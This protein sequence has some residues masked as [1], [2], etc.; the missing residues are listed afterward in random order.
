MEK[1]TKNASMYPPKHNENDTKDNKP[2]KTDGKKYNYNLKRLD[3]RTP[4]REDK[5]HKIGSVKIS[6]LIRAKIKG[7][8]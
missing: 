8:Y 1:L 3:I 6:S 7:A 5:L 2:E 4:E